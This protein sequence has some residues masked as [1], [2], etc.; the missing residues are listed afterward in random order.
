MEDLYEIPNFRGYYKINKKGDVFT[1]K[2]NRHG[3]S[4]TGRLLAKVFTPQGY[5]KVTLHIDKNSTQYT[6]HALMAITFLNH[7]LDGTNKTVVDHKNKNRSDNNLDNLQLLTNRE[8]SSKDKTGGSSKYTGVCWLKNRNKWESRI[9]FKG[10]LRYLGSFIDE[11]DAHLA[12]QDALI[13][14]KNG[15]F[16]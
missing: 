4:E 16:I 8:N 7:T 5:V 9:R 3:F 6:V 13:K 11:Y 10:R 1:F 12:Y 15:T 14:I 2:N